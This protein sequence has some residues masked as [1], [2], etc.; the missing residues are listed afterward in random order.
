MNTKSFKH[1]K[2]GIY[3]YVLEFLNRSYYVGIS[4]NPRN[5]FKMHISGQTNDFVKKNRPILDIHYNLL[6]TTSR[7][8]ALVIEDNKTIDLIHEHGI[9]RVSGGIFT[10]DIY[11]RTLKYIIYTERN[12]NSLKKRIKKGNFI[13]IDENKYSGIERIVEMIN[14]S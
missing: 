11:E 8:K 3:L 7:A 5:R 9:G 1:D 4:N 6:N 13:E 10:G 12:R 14:K 2:Y